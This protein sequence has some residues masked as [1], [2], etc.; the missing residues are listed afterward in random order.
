MKTIEQKL[1]RI[2]KLWC[3]FEVL[4]N[5]FLI[6]FIVFFGIALIYRHHF[7]TWLVVGMICSIGTMLTKVL[8]TK[9]I[10][11]ENS[12]QFKQFERDW[13]TFMVK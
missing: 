10:S 7:L 1:S 9:Y 3:F 13:N 8:A 6:A 12:L 4:S 5:V 11:I 2:R